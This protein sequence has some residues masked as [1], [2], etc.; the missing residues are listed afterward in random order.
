M[1][2]PGST[3]SPQMLYSAFSAL[4]AATGMSPLAATYVLSGLLFP[5]Q[6]LTLTLLAARGAMC[7]THA[8]WTRVVKPAIASALEQR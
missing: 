3:D 5:V 7:V 6:T 8:A 1:C 2:D 4:G